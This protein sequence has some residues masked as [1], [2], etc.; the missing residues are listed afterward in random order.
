[1][2]SA[3]DFTQMD[4]PTLL[5][6]RRRVREALERQPEP[7]A[8]LAVRYQRLDDEFIRRARIAWTEG[9]QK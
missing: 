7:N 5:S 1:M 8:E 4:D 6:E 2:T 9:G 3:D